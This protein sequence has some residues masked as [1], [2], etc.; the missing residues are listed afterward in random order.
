VLHDCPSHGFVRAANGAIVT[1]DADED[2]CTPTSGTAGMSINTAGTI[3]G[4]CIDANGVYH[5][6]TRAAAAP[7]KITVFDV[8]G[9]G[10][11]V[12]LAKLS[13]LANGPPTQGTAALS[14]NT[15]GDVAGVYADTKGV[16]HGF[17]RTAKG[18][19]LYP[20]NA[21]GFGTSPMQGTAAIS[22]NDRGYVVGAFADTNEAVHG[23]IAPLLVIAPK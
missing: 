6:F 7:N 5:G 11:E 9:A 8:P 10:Q 17:L 15:A 14:I 23:F 2:G 22:I 4:Y 19:M 18:A 1:F 20:I 21:P 13:A 16:Y 3:A 12:W